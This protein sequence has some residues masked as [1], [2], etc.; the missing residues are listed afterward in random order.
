MMPEIPLTELLAVAVDTARAAGSLLIQNDQHL[1]V[2][3]MEN[4]KDVKLQA[5]VAAEELIR[6]RLEETE[7]PDDVR[8]RED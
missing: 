4:A 7:L 1:R 5:D 8:V 2:V 3:H 6:E